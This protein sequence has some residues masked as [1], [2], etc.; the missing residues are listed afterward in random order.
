MDPL[1]PL[2]SLA[3]EVEGLKPTATVDKPIEPRLFVVSR[4]AEAKEIVSIQQVS[5][6]EKLVELS[7]ECSKTSFAG[8]VQPAELGVAKVHSYCKRRCEIA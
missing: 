7:P 5:D 8:V 1:N 3:G 6:I 4:S 2:V